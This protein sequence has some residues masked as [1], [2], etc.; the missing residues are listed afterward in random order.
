MAKCKVL[1]LKGGAGSADGFESGNERCR[2]VAIGFRGYVENL[3]KSNSLTK[4]EVYGGDRPCVG[5]RLS[6]FA[7]LRLQHA[8]YT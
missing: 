1:Q 8:Y 2:R 3:V 5:H 4:I 6:T 7:L